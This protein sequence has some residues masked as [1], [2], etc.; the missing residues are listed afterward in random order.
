MSL[1]ATSVRHGYL[2]GAGAIVNVSCGF[3]P[4]RVD[5]VNVTDGTVAVI[6]YGDVLIAFTSGGVAVPVAGM[7]IT[8]ITSGAV[9]KIKDIILISGTYAAGSAAG[10]FICDAEDVTGTFQSE[11]VTLTGSAAANDDGTVV[12]QIN[13][14]VYQSAALGF[15]AGAAATTGIAS[16]LGDATHAKGFSIGATVAVSGKMLRWTAYR[17]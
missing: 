1:A 5:V 12:V 17:E 11:N 13:H 10:W 16:Y 15:V 9:A 3:V 14:S 8:G 6:G 4:K 7:K 2:L